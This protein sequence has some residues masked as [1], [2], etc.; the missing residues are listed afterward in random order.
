[1]VDLPADEI[2]SASKDRQARLWIDII[3]PTPEEVTLVFEQ[4]YDLHPLSIEDTINDIHTPKLDNYGSYLF[5]VFHAVGLG[6]ERMDLH[7]RELDVFL[8]Q[9]F[10]ITIHTEQ[11]PEIGAMWNGAHHVE[12]GLADGTVYLLYE[13]LDR[14]IDNY[15]P[16]IDR[17]EERLEALGDII[18]R[19]QT[20]HSDD[21]IL[22]DILTS[23]SSALRLRR[24][25]VPQRDIMRRLAWEDFA[26]VPAEA[27]IY[28]RD[29]YDHL[30]RLSDLVESMRDLASSTIETHLALVNNR[31]NEV[32][33]VLTIISTIFIPLGFV[34]GVYGMNF[35]YMPELSARIA[36]PLVWIAF[37]SIAG[38]MLFFFRRR[39]WI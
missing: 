31:M 36:Y 27:R 33:K 15:I 29:V 6:D 19:Q 25:L 14:Q 5:M 7:T 30:E 21:Q 16:M 35:D 20:K 22:N 9:N 32:M 10:L 28:Y 37:L 17:F 18:F 4:A 13:L 39:R 24:I 1:M 38:G 3:S 34:S 23:K 2:L 12:H 26:V 11:M 8:G